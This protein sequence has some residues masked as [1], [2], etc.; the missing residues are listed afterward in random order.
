M[1]AIAYALSLQIKQPQGVVNEIYIS[2][3]YTN[4]LNP[5]GTAGVNW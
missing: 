2:P 5:E 1:K 4:K 3:D